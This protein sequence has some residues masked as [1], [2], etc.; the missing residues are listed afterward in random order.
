MAS[1][2]TVLGAGTWGVSLARMLA[3]EKHSVKVWSAVSEEIDRLVRTYTHPNIGGMNLPDTIRFTKN[4]ENAV[5]DAEIIVLAV[6]SVFVRETARKMSEFVS[7][8]TIIVDAAKGMEDGTFMTLSEVIKEEVP[9]GRVAVLSGPTHAE[10]VAFDIPTAVVAASDDEEVA[11]KV[12]EVFMTKNF[13]VYTNT[14]TR[15]VEVAG[16]IKNIMALGVGICRGLGCGDNTTAALITRGLSEIVA[17]GEAM[18]CSKETFYGLA[19]IGDLIVTCTSVHSR[20]FRAGK[21]IGEGKSAKAAVEEIGMVVEGINMLPAAMHLCEK[22]GIDMPI[23]KRVDAVV[24]G[25]MP[26]RK[27]LEEL[28]TRSK[29]GE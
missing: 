27:A 28:M 17:L 21:L 19:G 4:I 2:V 10:E 13:R 11:I 29:R 12:Q 20:N 22:Y 8:G 9:Q 24:A 18:G 5:S 26:A 6:P 7:E 16:A 23:A 3:K 25:K 14:D 15:G 1:K